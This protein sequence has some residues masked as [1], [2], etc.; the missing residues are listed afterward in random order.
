M[1]QDLPDRTETGAIV[2]NENALN[3]RGSFEGQDVLKRAVKLSG[4]LPF[5]ETL[6]IDE[7]R[8]FIID[9]VVTGVSHSVDPKSETLVRTHALKVEAVEPY[10]GVA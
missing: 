7:T 4:T 9:V 5:E 3:P 8:R 2:S 10:P 6:T 1:S